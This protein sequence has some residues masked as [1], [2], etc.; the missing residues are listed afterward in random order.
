MR[1]KSISIIVFLFITFFNDAQI[2]YYQETCQCG[3]TG[4]GF[5]TALGNGNGNF[6]IYIEPGSTVKKALLFGINF[7][8]ENIPVV[9]SNILLNSQIITFD[10]SNSTNLSFSAYD[11]NDLWDAPFISIHVSDL[12]TVLDP[13]VLNYAIQIQP[14]LGNCSSCQFNCY[15]LYVLYENA[16]FLGNTTS[17]VLLN[18]KDELN[19]VHYELSLLNQIQN[20]SSIGFATYFDRLGA[21]IPTDGT[22]LWLDN[23]VLNNVGLLKG[24]DSA[25]ST[26]DGAGVKGHFYFQ[27]NTLFGLDD[28]TPDNVVG[29][30][31]GL[32]DVSSYLHPDGSLKWDLKWENNLNPNGRYNIYNG[33]FIEHS[34]PC[35][36]FSVS[37]P[38]DTTICR[39]ESLQ[40]N[41][42]GGSQYEWQPATDLS[43]S[44]CPN[45][46]FTGDST[47]LYTV[48]IWN[49]DSCSVVRPV[50]ITV[51]NCAGINENILPESF[52]IYPNPT[53]GIFNIECTETLVEMQIEVLDLLGKVHFNDSFLSQKTQ[54]FHLNLSPGIYLIKVSKEGIEFLTKRIVLE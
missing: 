52:S 9:P 20:A 13:L 32:I 16:S 47:Q 53:A 50:K 46:V 23:G 42:T 38:S 27:N 41:A 35:D 45:P 10:E 22:S 54:T 21:L 8:E 44:T 48:R 43:C 34:T 25:N 31:D 1:I 15:Y 4:A 17:Y 11:P 29:G 7:G 12:T 26:W 28:D 39:G 24:G 30:T 40:L 19:S 33:F 3:V 51:D 2:V 49:N 36:T 37:V 14:Q 6:S 18:N 5:S